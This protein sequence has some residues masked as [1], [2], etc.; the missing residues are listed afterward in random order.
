MDLSQIQEKASKNFRR[1][2]SEKMKENEH[3]PLVPSSLGR[4]LGKLHFQ[5]ACF[6]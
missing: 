2:V 1:F 5:V 3:C 6:D 4:R